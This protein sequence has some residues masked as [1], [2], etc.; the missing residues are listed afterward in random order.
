M[1]IQQK[2]QNNLK[3]SSKNREDKIRSKDAMLDSSTRKQDG[4]I[5]HLILMNKL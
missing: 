4:Q 2:L 5:L 3:H 1:K